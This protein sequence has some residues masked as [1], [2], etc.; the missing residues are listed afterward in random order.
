[1]SIFSI[2]IQLATDGSEVATLA[3]PTAIDVAD[4]IDSE[5]HLVLAGLSGSY[6]GMGPLDIA[7]ITSP[8]HEELNHKAQRLIKCSVDRS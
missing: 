1:M 4:K 5:L 7:D 3:A 8:T 6:V 2:R